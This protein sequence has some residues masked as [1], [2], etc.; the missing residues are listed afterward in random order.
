LAR[1]TI[2]KVYKSYD[3]LI[4][5]MDD[6]WYYKVESD[7]D[8]GGDPDLVTAEM[9]FADLCWLNEVSETDKKEHKEEEQAAYSERQREADERRLQAAVQALGPERV[10]AY[11]EAQERQTQESRKHYE[12]IGQELADAFRKGIIG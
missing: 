9:N 2:V 10:K 11:L 12:L 7:V 3:R 8:C 1:K 6:H 4:L 5:L